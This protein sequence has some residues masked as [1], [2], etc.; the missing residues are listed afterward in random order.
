MKALAAFFGSSVFSF[1]FV[2]CPPL[3]SAPDAAPPTPT[4][5]DAAPAVDASPKPDASP[6]GDATPADAAR[7]PCQATCDALRR[8]G[9]REGAVSD[10]AAKIC[11]VNADPRFLHYNVTCLQTA[12]TPAN[13]AACG[14]QCTP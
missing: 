7:S 11:Q 8:A 2:A 13:V 10:C 1:A 5:V 4:S 3:P 6:F 12:S 14:G 9:C